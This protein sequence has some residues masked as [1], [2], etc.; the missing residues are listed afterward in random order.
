M[1]TRT[2]T[3]FSAP[4]TEFALARFAVQFA[5]TVP[6]LSTRTIDAGG[7]PDELDKH[8]YVATVPEHTLVPFL[9]ETQSTRLLLSQVLGLP[10]DSSWFWIH[11]RRENLL[12]DNPVGKPGDFDI[13]CG[14]LRDGRPSS[15]FLC[16]V[17]VK[18]RRVDPSG[19]AKAF[20]SGKGEAQVAGLVELGFDRS[21]LMHCLVSERTEYHPSA[22]STWQGMLNADNRDAARATA[23][24]LSSSLPPGA[25]HAILMIGQGQN[26]DFRR[27]HTAI[28]RVPCAPPTT[29][30]RDSTNIRANALR[31]RKNVARRLGENRTGSLFRSN[32]G[33]LIQTL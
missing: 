16:G 30:R 29:P 21:L 2:L 14:V 4:L 32:R 8:G 13:I 22:S 1:Q 7:D 9:V 27:S 18:R 26:R 25:G 31:L 24:A 12:P 20:P 23:S 33:G 28:V 3:N 17:E 15:E 10:P 11:E 6:A 5:G 19:R